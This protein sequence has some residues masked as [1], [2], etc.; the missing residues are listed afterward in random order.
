MP[1]S[2]HFATAVRPAPNCSAWTAMSDWVTCVRM[3]KMWEK[4]SDLSSKKMSG[5]GL[6]SC[7]TTARLTNEWSRDDETQK[8]TIEDKTVKVGDWV[9]F[10]C[11]IEQSGRI[12]EIRAGDKW[13]GPELLLAPPE[14][15]FDGDYIKL[16]DRHLIDASDCWV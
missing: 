10:K 6:T 1:R 3:A 8:H 7:R 11:D 4:I 16:S 9:G 13:R 15:G 2:R 5:T 12:L 14:G